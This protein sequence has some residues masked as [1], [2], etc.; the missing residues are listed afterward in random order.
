MTKRGRFAS[1]RIGKAC[2]G[3]AKACRLQVEALESRELL[4]GD[5][6][7]AA[8]LYLVP[9]A[10]GVTTTAL[11]TVG[12]VIDRT[13]VPAQQY[14]LT[15][16]PDG[17]GAAAAGAGNVQLFMNHEFVN[18]R[19]SVPIVN[20]S[21]VTGAYV[22]RFV[23]SGSDAEPLSG[24]QAYTKVVRGT[25][26]TPLT[27]AFGRF[28]SGFLGGP[29]VGLDRLIYFCAEETSA[30]GTFDGKGGQAVAIFDGVAH[31]LPELS[32]FEK[33]NV[34]VLPNTGDKTVILTTE[35]AGSLTSQLYMYVGTKN[36]SATDPLVK[37]GLV[38]G[39]L[40]VLAAST[41]GQGEN[42]FHKGDG[43]LSLSWV[44]VPDPANKVDPT[45]PG[46]TDATNLEKVVQG[47]KSFN[48]VRVED[49]AFDRNQPGTFYFITTGSGAES[50]TNPNSLGRLYRA[51]IDPSNPTAGAKLTVLLEGD[52][53]DPFVNPD[54]IDL[55]AQ[56]Q[57][58]I[59]EDPNSP[60]HNG[61]N[62]AGDAFWAARGNRDSSVW[63]YDT[64]SGA[65]VRVAQIDRATAAASVPA[66]LGNNPGVKGS[67]ETSGVIDVSALYGPGAWL[68]DVQGHTIMSNNPLVGNEGGQL[69]LLRADG[70]I[71]QLD[72][73]GDLVVLGTAG[74]D[75]IKVEEKHGLILVR[76]NGELVGSF[77]AG[78]VK[79]IT[80]NANDGDDR[81]EVDRHIDV[82]VRLFGGRGEDDLRGGGKDNR[83]DGGPG[84][85]TLR[86]RDG[87]HDVFVL[88]AGQGTDT[89]KG[90]EEDEDKVELSGGLVFTDVAVSQVG[91][92][93]VLSVDRPTLVGRAVLPADSFVAGPTSGQFITPANGRT[94]PFINRQPLQGFSAILR[95]NDG[96]YLVMSDNGY[97][98][99]DNSADFLLRVDRI[100][101]NFRTANGGS[102][103]V[104]IRSEFVLRDPDHKVN[105][106]IVAD[107][108]F[109][110]NGAGNVPVDPAIKAGRLLTGAD[111]DIESFRQVADG[112]FWFGDEFGPF[113]IHTDA[114]GKVLD[115]PIP[116]PG[117]K[118]PQH[119]FLQPGETPNLARSHGFEGMAL[120]ADGKKLYPLLEG[121]LTTD[122]DRRRLTINEFD[123]KTN[124]FTG[125]SWYYEM[126]NT[127][128]SGQSIGDMTAVNDHQFLVIERDNGQGTAA[129]FK[130]IFLIDFNKTDAQGNLIKQ[131]VVNLLNIADPN[132]LGGTGTGKFTFPFQ[133]IEGV[134]VLDQWTLVVTNDNN[135]PF[136]AGRTPG[137]PDPNED[138]L[139]SLSE[140]LD[141][142]V[143]TYPTVDVGTSRII[144]EKTD[145]EDIRPGT[146][147]S[148]PL[149]L[150]HR[151]IEIGRAHV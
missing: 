17:L 54:N 140:P 12:D 16:I 38:G 43:T 41:A 88:T 119:P 56:G 107:M 103:D 105:F 81:V 114:T 61:G 5:G 3:R 14:R 89:V 24:D 143:K 132:H 147:V 122:P 22:S 49:V 134:Q 35:D 72:G 53:G 145:S 79:S 75:R 141:V 26:P 129:K 70:P 149:I 137:Q 92:D 85:D 101:P 42:T 113:L 138:L 58:L 44:E 27:G 110:P 30:P 148:R 46:V 37:N 95:Q 64:A 71:A 91:G 62:A 57:M 87:A 28:C 67:W 146:F 51:S 59:C 96:S 6:F 84:Q 15:G 90:F 21:P 36:P 11:L 1:K 111:F 25:D 115:A 55:N 39:K 108:E 116:L 112:T 2:R 117:V 136:S 83:L 45:A 60:E 69:L 150:G 66:A 77:P 93:T 68:I 34:V 9:V 106:P 99:K 121:P 48:F 94:P 144:L 7:T 40:Y 118:S 142:T 23:L 133:T 97:G 123:L 52:K 120:S 151:G 47:L 82:P 4:A 73:N 139:I 109:Y 78:Q 19:T 100:T 31:I 98:A 128:E 29:E 130:K 63:L 65:L 135:Y 124:S 10:G 74:D 127:T 32:H 102:G 76:V 33:E 80:V 20:A 104:S 86:A 125:R 50:P 18:T 8:P 131:E 126:D 13:G